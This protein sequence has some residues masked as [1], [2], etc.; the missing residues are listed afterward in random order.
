[1]TVVVRQHD[2]VGGRLDQ[3]SET[4]F[5][6]AQR[7]FGVFGL[8]GEGL[9]ADGPVQ[10]GPQFIPVIGFGKLGECALCQ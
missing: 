1:M 2:G 7:M 6:F 3:G 5:A 4:C 10:D 8:G 9:D